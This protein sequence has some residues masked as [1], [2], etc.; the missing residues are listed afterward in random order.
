M[1]DFGELSRAVEEDSA[2]RGP[3]AGFTGRVDEVIQTM[4]HRFAAEGGARTC[5]NW[6][7][8]GGL[9]RFRTG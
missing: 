2:R 9:L 5:L 3:D 6:R 7:S 8:T 4:R 1:R